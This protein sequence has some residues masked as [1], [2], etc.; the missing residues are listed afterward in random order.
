M[1][2]AIENEHLKVSFAKKGAEIQSIKSVHSSTEFMWSG[3]PDYWGKFSPVLFPIIGA[4][5][6]DTYI[7][8]E[9]KYHL[10]RHGF[11][12][13]MDFEHEQ[14]SNHEVVF[15][16]S[17]NDETLKVY[18]FEFVLSL[19]YK[20]T[21]AT[22]S[23]TY[24]VENPANKPL[25]FSVGGHPAFAAPID[26]Q[27]NYTDYY[28]RFNKDN[29][30]TYHHIEANLITD[31]T[32]TITLEGNKLPLKHELFYDDALVFKNL[33]SDK[34]SLLNS[35]NYNGIEFS[36]SD[37][38]FFGIWAAKDADFVCLEPWCGIADGLNDNQNLAEKE[39]INTL[40]AKGNWQRTWQVTCF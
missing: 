13:D 39:G 6:D 28:L 31:K 34:I 17:H 8:E 11:A 23:C 19:R 5:K 12:R 26:R 14:I 27:G 37:F 29:A 35:K 9:Q 38:P 1:M 18:P 2:I 20:I 4:L 36:F 10:P 16:L 21:G 40:D 33:Q 7:Y 15:K 30:L 24:E 3:N 32:T 22:L 25:L